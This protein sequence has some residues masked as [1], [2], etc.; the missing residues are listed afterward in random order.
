MVTSAAVRD[1]VYTSLAT[2]TTWL[3]FG[4]FDFPSVRVI[5]VAGTTVRIGIS[6]AV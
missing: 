6:D 3:A 5:A 1:D 2:L 4:F